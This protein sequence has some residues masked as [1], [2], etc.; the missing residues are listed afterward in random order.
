MDEWEPHAWSATPA[1]PRRASSALPSGL[2]SG[3]EGE[4]IT[5]HKLEGEWTGL[6]EDVEA[7]RDA[8]LERISAARGPAL[9]W[10]RL[11]RGCARILGWQNERQGVLTDDTLPPWSDGSEE[12]EKHPLVKA[13]LRPKDKND[14]TFWMPF[15]ELISGSAGFVKLDFCDRTTKKDLNLKLKEDLGMFGIIFGCLKGLC[16]FMFCRGMWVIYCGSSSSGSTRSTKRGCDACIGCGDD[17]VEPKAVEID[18]A[19]RAHSRMSAN[20]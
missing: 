3:L 13:R 14:G 2:P 7:L 5:L 15:D 17:V 8:L 4:V 18:I 12:W 16:R 6:E 11:R 9:E 1:A 20:L 19:H 10:A